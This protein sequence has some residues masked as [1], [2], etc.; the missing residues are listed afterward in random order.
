MESCVD[1]RLLGDED[2]KVVRIKLTWLKC[3]LNN[4]L[5]SPK[6]MFRQL[7]FQ[8]RIMTSPFLLWALG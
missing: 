6:G 5:S 8:T 3:F 4:L 1:A 2:D 7:C